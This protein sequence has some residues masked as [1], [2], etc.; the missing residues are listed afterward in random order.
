MTHATA[1]KF[2]YSNFDK[3]IKQELDKRKTFKS[4]IEKTFSIFNEKTVDTTSKLEYIAKDYLHNESWVFW[5]VIASNW[6]YCPF[7]VNP[8]TTIFDYQNYSR[9]VNTTTSGILSR[10]T[11]FL[12]VNQY[13]PLILMKYKEPEVY[14]DPQLI[15][16]LKQN[17]RPLPT[18]DNEFGASQRKEREAYFRAYPRM[19]FK[20]NTL[21]IPWEKA[22][23]FATTHS[24][25]SLIVDNNKYE[26]SP[27]V[28]S[29]LNCYMLEKIFH[30]RAI[31]RFIEYDMMNSI[32]NRLSYYIDKNIPYVN[33]DALLINP[34]V[35]DIYAAPF[36]INSPI[37][38][39]PLICLAA[40]YFDKTYYQY[41]WLYSYIMHWN[42]VALPML[43][44]L[45]LWAV[46]NY[47]QDSEIELKIDEACQI[48][49]KN[50]SFDYK[51]IE[52]DI[53]KDKYK[54]MKRDY[55]SID[56]HIRFIDTP[57]DEIKPFMIDKYTRYIEWKCVN[58]SYN[59]ALFRD[60]TKEEDT[61]LG[62]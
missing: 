42:K 52:I 25:D 4:N 59:T 20:N 6:K 41:N 32:Y 51:Y 34:Q 38:T 1:A 55:V 19:Y 31:N 5:T 39:E 3:P 56:N 36:L 50:M 30:F 45:F 9:Y 47:I 60:K 33:E 16:F 35:N 22:N 14:C 43:E 11:T 53:P 26:V 15:Q 40:K 48:I 61:T 10:L 18:S 57:D 54:F 23:C 49:S 62:S 8:E 28:Q 17:N 2:V 27:V 13:L 46:S 37:L 58:S 21:I 29:V 12:S 7:N 24:L 44:E